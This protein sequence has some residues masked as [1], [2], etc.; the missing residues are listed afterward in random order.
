MDSATF[1]GHLSADDVKRNAS[2]R[3]RDIL[4]ANG[5]NHDELDGRHHPCPKCGGVDRFSLLD[6]SEGAVLCRQC[7]AEKNGDG[8]AA[9]QWRNDWTF[10]QTIRAVADFLGMDGGERSRLDIVA[11]VAR[12][13]RMPVESFRAF[14]ATLDRRGNLEVA[15]VPMFDQHRNQCSSFDLSNISPE[16]SKGMSA[17]GQP[18]GLFVATWPGE[19]D[20]VCLVEGVKD[21]AALH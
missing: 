19:G 9:I 13:K 12:S 18:L 20:T 14:G 16:F 1:N 10:S 6:E 17:K 11:D 2:G 5:F 4:A 15:R 3:W 8:L 21:A 7:F